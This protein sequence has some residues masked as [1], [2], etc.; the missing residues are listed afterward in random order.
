[1]RQG[2]PGS[3]QMSN[4]AGPRR[5]YELNPALA[6]QPA[7][8]IERLIFPNLADKPIPFIDGSIEATHAALHA[9]SAAMVGGTDDMCLENPGPIPAGYTYFSQFVFHDMAFTRLE[10]RN[11]GY[12]ARVASPH[13]ASDCTAALDLDTLYG[14]GPVFEPMLYKAPDSRFGHRCEFVT[15]MPGEQI[16]PGE[17]TETE[18]ANARDLP[19]IALDGCGATSARSR[20][21]RYSQPVVADARNDHHLILAQMHATFLKVHN[22]IVGVLRANGAEP[23]EAFEITRAFV[24]SSY[25][26]AIFLDYLPRILHPAIYREL[27]GRRFDAYLPRRGQP[28]V[29][30]GIPLEFT[31]GTG[32]LGHAMSRSVYRVNRFRPEAPLPEIINLSSEAPDAK[33]PVSADWYIDWTN[34]F[35]FSTLASKVQSARRIS[36][37]MSS[38]M[39]QDTTTILADTDR[40]IGFM[41]MWRCY[42]RRL[43]SG[44][45]LARR[46]NR[47]IG[48]LF[49]TE[50]TQKGGIPILEKAAMLPS[51]AFAAVYPADAE[52]LRAAL[53]AAPEFLVHTPLFYYLAQEAAV[54]GEE[55]GRLGPVGSFILA[56]A[57]R[58]A[59]AETD[60]PGVETTP[61]DLRHSAGIG[62]VPGII[63][64]AEAGVM[65]DEHLYD[66][67]STFA[68][69]MRRAGRH[70]RFGPV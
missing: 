22:R 49:G 9:I 44:Q 67:V 26:K 48:D 1:M 18:R 50:L 70:H 69:Q 53:V 25:R 2:A 19:R 24:G 65:T 62:T 20:N 64:I 32:R 17:M 36:P 3:S 55:G 40:S 14:S 42:E 31:F 16:L 51:D 13:I 45:I 15:G 66:L 12:T 41:D 56:V 4:P 29:A 58:Q 60:E 33:L 23:Q 43:P 37:F 10:N 39:A 46:I 38:A 47:E 59:L 6:G 11:H 34:F 68:G 5:G 8:S 57:A 35:E 61:H 63:E 30:L 27:F 52:R 54:L 28:G 21:P 7:E